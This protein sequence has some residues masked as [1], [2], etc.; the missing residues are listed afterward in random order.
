MTSF[1][2]SFSWQG[3]EYSAELNKYKF[4]PPQFHIR[5]ITP[6]PV[7]YRFDTIF[8]WDPA[9]AG[10]TFGGMPDQTWG[11]EISRGILATCRE[12]GI[13]LEQ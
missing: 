11:N 9:K 7:D 2:I 5:N 3:E 4:A 1:S 8:T 12:K 10:L 6:K 13:S